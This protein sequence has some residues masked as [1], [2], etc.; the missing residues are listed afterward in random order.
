MQ[1]VGY[2]TRD[3]LR[4]RIFMLTGS[5][6]YASYYYSFQATPL[7]DPLITNCILVVANFAIIVVVVIERTTFSMPKETAEIFKLFPMLTPDQFRRLLKAGRI[8]QP[9]AP[10]QLTVEGDTPDALYFIL[11][12]PVTLLKGDQETRLNHQMFIG[13]LAFLAGNPASATVTADS[14]TR[15]LQWD[16][17][18][19][20]RLI[21]KSTNRRSCASR[22]RRNSTAISCRRSPDR[23]PRCHPRRC[24]VPDLVLTH[25]WHRPRLRCDPSDLR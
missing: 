15:F 12:G 1:L 7:W 9:T 23:N 5:V 11:D 14:G 6:L 25:P 17:A 20:R 13:E 22:L 4:L 24:A 10:R 8:V 19:L 18:T 3:E 2:L 16:N 21:D